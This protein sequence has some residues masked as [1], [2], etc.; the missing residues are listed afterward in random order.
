MPTT[1]LPD[2]ARRLRWRLRGAWLGP[3][4]V[5][6][7]V[8]DTI[9]LHQLPVAGEDKTA[10]V[11]A[12]LL[13]G[14]INL[15]V[16]AALGHLAGLL[17]RRRRPDLPRVVADNY[18]G[19]ALL[20]VVTAVFL[21]F[22]LAHRPTVDDEREAARDARSAARAYLEEHAPPAYRSGIASASVYRID[23]DIFRVCANADDPNRSWCV[24]VHTDAEPP[25]V[26]EDDSHT[27]NAAL[28][29]VRSR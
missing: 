1:Q 24:V 16:V 26:I 2:R 18:A 11:S 20:I 5:G 22:G 21:A 4:F 6:L 17:L 13:A 10:W 19:T 14:C 15:I 3:T 9:L 8:V 23:R 7:T 29:G 27:P 28:D 25:R 12:F